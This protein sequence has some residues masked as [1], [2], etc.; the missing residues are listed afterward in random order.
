M[1]NLLAMFVFL[2]GAA[3]LVPVNTAKAKQA[4][5][6]VAGK[7]HFILS[8]DGGDRIFEPEFKQDGDQVTGKWGADG[9]VKGTFTDGKLSLE[10]PVTSEEA[11]PGTLKIK[12]ALADDAISG[13]W[14]FN[15]YAG[16]FKATRIK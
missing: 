11:G 5:P 12:G 6:T 2:M 3:L 13:E 10:F 7:W 16:S 9:N 4:T 15:D 1:K 14:A 8:T